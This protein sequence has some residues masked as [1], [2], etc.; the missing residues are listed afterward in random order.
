MASLPAATPTLPPVTTAASASAGGIVPLRP[1]STPGTANPMWVLTVASLKMYFR[2]RSGLFFSFVLPVLIMSI[3]GVLNFGGFGSVS[4]GVVDEAQTDITR[5]LVA[6]F[7]QVPSVKVSTGAADVEQA[8]L[9]R[10][11][12]DLVVILPTALRSVSPASAGGPPVPLTVY[13]N[14]NRQ[15]QSQV[16][17]SLLNQVLQQTQMQV[18]GVQP[19]W[20]IETQ[21]LSSRETRY[22]DALV[23]GVLAMSIMQMGLF[24]VTFAFVQL[25]RRGVLRRMLA[26]P[27]RPSSFLVAQVI[28]RLVVSMVQTALLLIVGVVLLKV[29]F[30]G[31]YVWLML[32][33][34]LGG[35]VFL[36]MGFAVSGIARTEEVAAPV[37]NLVAMPQMFLSGVF[38]PREVIPAA[39]RGVT[40]I[41]PLSF[42]GDAMR[43]VALDGATPLQLGHDLIGLGVW[44]LVSFVLAVRLFRWE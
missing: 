18:L 31:S 32:L 35:A 41:L 7:A 14:E 30:A 34:L 6:A 1:P 12:R 21:S 13:M 39:L 15:A 10:G 28:T 5:R 11:E 22:V 4:L 3:F 43:A 8:A 9:Q 27:L 42:L 25:K 33:A 26:S 20:R 24:S 19:L 44:L 29:Q 16:G 17:L 40:D 38:F 23:P 36:A 37:G 2:N